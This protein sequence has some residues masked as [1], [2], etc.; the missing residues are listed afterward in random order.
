MIASKKMVIT[1]L[2]LFINPDNEPVEK[3]PHYD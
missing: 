3:P 2:D 1:A